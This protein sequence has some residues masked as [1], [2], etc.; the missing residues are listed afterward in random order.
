M[1][2]H[3]HYIGGE[4]NAVIETVGLKRMPAWRHLGLTAAQAYTKTSRVY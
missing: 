2:P 1:V 3:M 4:L